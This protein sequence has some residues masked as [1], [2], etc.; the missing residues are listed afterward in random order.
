MPISPWLRAR[1]LAVG[2]K[3][4]TH[5]RPD[6]LTR[7]RSARQGRRGPGKEFIADGVNYAIDAGPSRL[8]VENKYPIER[9][10]YDEIS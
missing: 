7:R 10:H 2:S 3:P 6:A 1:R 5:F 8:I 4:G 9:M